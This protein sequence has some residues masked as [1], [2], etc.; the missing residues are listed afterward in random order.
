MP[1]P[2]RSL[3]VRHLPRVASTWQRMSPLHILSSRGFESISNGVILPNPYQRALT[4][5]RLPD[6][7]AMLIRR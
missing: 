5:M 4:R 2:L 6:G 7:S 1:N 3:E